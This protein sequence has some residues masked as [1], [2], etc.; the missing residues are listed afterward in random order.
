MGMNNLKNSPHSRLL[1]DIKPERD[2]IP[3]SRYSQSARHRLPPI[4]A[5]NPV[6][7]LAIIHT[8]FSLRPCC[9]GANHAAQIRRMLLQRRGYKALLD[10]A[11]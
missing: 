11:E 10:S 6:A 8:L 4:S 7:R 9:R 1:D 3:R 2:I 5:E